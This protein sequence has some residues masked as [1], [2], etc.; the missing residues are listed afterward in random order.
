MPVTRQG[1][2]TDA[3][4]DL[5]AQHVTDALATYETNRNTGNGNGNGSGSQFNSGSGR[6]RTVHTARGC[7]YKE[8]LNCQPLNFKGTEGLT[9]GHDAAYEMSWKDLIKIMT[10]AY[11]PRNE[12][13]KLENE[14]WNLTVKVRAYAARQIE[15]KRILENN[16]RDDH[17]WQPPYKR[18][19][20][21]RAYTAG[22]SEKREYVGTLPLCNKCTLH[23]NGPC[24]K[25]CGN[26]KKVGHLAKDCRGTTAAADQRAPVANQRTFTCFECGNQGHYRSECSKLKNQNRENQA[27]SSEERGSMYALGGGEVDHSLNNIADDTDA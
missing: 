5:I 19:N 7:T 27:G 4:E 1:M 3:I 21:A 18:Q 15:N 13:K 20:I 17:A 9:V 10:E 12:I 26:C 6:R 11:C 23:H 8:F 2:T 22:P 16:T 14:L 25:K 24:T